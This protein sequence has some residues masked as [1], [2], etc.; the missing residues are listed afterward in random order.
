[1]ALHGAFITTLVVD[2]STL[3]VSG[4]TGSSWS[5]SLDF[6]HRA[7]V[8]A[9]VMDGSTLAVRG[10]AGCGRSQSLNFLS[11]TLVAAFWERGTAVSSRSW[12]RRGLGLD[13]SNLHSGQSL[14]ATRASDVTV[15]AVLGD[16]R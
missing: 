15:K 10:R 4:R 9:L 2:G 13:L 6:I 5:L 8:T 1:M 11:R 3:A 12:C 14:N 7:L 16:V